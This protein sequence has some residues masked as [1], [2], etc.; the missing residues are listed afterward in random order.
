MQ[1]CRMTT[2]AS[3][4]LTVRS[5]TGGARRHIIGVASEAG[6]SPIVATLAR[7][8]RDNLSWH[9]PPKA[10]VHQ[11]VALGMARGGM[12]VAAEVARRLKVPLDV[13]VVRKIGHPMRPELGL[14]AIAEGD[15]MILNESLIEDWASPRRRWQPWPSASRPSW[16]AECCAIAPGMAPMAVT[17]RDVILVDDGL[18]TGY[19]A[20]AAIASLRNRGP[21]RITL[22]VPIASA[23]AMADL[24]A[25]ADK[26]VALNVPSPFVSVG[27]YYVDFRQ[28]SDE[29]VMALLAERTD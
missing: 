27:A 11:T 19:T 28:T 13:I 22:A 26:V 20:R 5:P 7:S 2:P 17:G 3:E 24:C 14:G 9:R 1:R 8:S 15:V 16:S 25:A 21:S 29:E 10:S 23:G 12:V 6:C 4:R 18:A